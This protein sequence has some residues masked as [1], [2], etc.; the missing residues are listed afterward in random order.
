[1]STAT[2]GRQ[3]EHRVRDDLAANG[4]YVI[5][6]AG[7]KGVMDLVAL[8]ADGTLLVQVKGGI[9]G[10]LDPAP[11]NALYDLA[12]LV[13]GVPVLAEVL[14]RKPIAYYRLAGR[15]DAPGRQPYVPFLL[16]EV[17]A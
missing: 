4:Y 2:R 8:K 6:A 13:G 9:A 14:P 12:A 16:D 3:Y 5:R 15:K 10:R 11:W 1:M 7:S 17:G